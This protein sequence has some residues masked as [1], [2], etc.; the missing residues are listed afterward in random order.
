MPEQK[1]ERRESK[2]ARGTK[3]QGGKNSEGE[4]VRWW[5]DRTAGGQSETVSKLSLVLVRQKGTP[6]RG[7]L[8][9]K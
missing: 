7:F 9:Q 8:I 3:T 2:I 6:E 4:R 5:A 1:G